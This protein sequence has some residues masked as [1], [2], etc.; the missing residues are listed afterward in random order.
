[1]AVSEVSGVWDFIYTD[2]ISKWALLRM[3]IVRFREC[4][5]PT[6]QQHAHEKF[7]RQQSDAFV[8]PRSSSAAEGSSRVTR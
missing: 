4:V 7:E 2:P 5:K 8:S 1:M 6:F 3:D